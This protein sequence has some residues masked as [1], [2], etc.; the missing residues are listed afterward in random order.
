MPDPPKIFRAEPPRLNIQLRDE[1]FSAL[2]RLV[3][4]GHRKHLFQAMTDDLI[5]LLESSPRREE[6]IAMI[7][8]RMIR[9]TD[10]TFSK[11]SSDA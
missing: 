3:P 1:Q 2:Q 7:I 4:H 9:I 5:A 11:E 6:V 10:I 8:C